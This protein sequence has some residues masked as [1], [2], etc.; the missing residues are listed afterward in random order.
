M[1]GSGSAGADEAEQS[2]VTKSIIT[3][4]DIPVQRQVTPRPSLIILCI[5]VLPVA[6]IFALMPFASN[7]QTNVEQKTIASVEKSAAALHII[8]VADKLTDAVQPLNRSS[9]LYGGVPLQIVI[10]GDDKSRKDLVSWNTDTLLAWKHFVKVDVMRKVDAM[11]PSPDDLVLFADAFDTLVTISAH[12]IVH[13]FNELE[14][15]YNLTN[16]VVFN[17]AGSKCF[18]FEMWKWKLDEGVML[19]NGANAT[20]REICDGFRARF[21]GDNP[22]LNSGVY[23]GRARDIAAINQFVWENRGAARRTDQ[24]LFMQASHA[25]RNMIVDSNS[26]FLTVTHLLDVQDSELC[27]SRN[28]SGGVLHFTGKNK[29]EWIAKCSKFYLAR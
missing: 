3:A 13:H 18:P 15:K 19:S 4:V 20:G 23:V 29:P 9:L 22:C 17:G 12:E 25:Y 24:S 6:V 21:G 27:A 28:V 11:V 5:F 7:V 14:R 1:T 8:S 16:A 26:T 2:S 10:D